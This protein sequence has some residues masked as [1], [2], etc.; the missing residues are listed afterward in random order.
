[1]FL[2]VQAAAAKKYREETLEP[3]FTK[4]EALLK[5]NNGGNGYFVGDEVSRTMEEIVT[6]WEMR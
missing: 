4:L 1:M 5:T 3:A 6:I 2:S